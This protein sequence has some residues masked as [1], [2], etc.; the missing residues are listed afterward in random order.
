M[1]SLSVTNLTNPEIGVA[2]VKRCNSATNDLKKDKISEFFERHETTRKIVA[3]LPTIVIGGSVLIEKTTSH[4]L[5]SDIGIVSGI[6]LT[7]MWFVSGFAQSP[8]RPLQDKKIEH[9]N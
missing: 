7:I 1:S 6:A 4:K 5:L 2:N 8:E 9:L 3:F